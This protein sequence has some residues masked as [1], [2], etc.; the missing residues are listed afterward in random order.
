MKFHMTLIA[1]FVD[2]PSCVG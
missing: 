1:F 2:R